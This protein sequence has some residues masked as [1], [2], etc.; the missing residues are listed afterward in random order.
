LRSS[1]FLFTS[2][3]DSS[4]PVSL[5]DKIDRAKETISRWF[6]ANRAADIT[7]GDL[8]MIIDEADRIRAKFEKNGPLGRFIG[9]AQLLI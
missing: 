3:D 8:D 7:P 2:L 6:V 1:A 4:L 5:R 9:D